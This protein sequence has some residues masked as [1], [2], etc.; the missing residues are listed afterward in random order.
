MQINIQNGKYPEALQVVDG[1]VK[2]MKSWKGLVSATFAK[3]DDITIT[4]ILVY[5]SLSSHEANVEKSREAFGQLSC[6]P[7][8]TRAPDRKFGVATHSI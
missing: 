7:Y 4:A 2:E 8:F 5:D 3:V 6:A 1:L